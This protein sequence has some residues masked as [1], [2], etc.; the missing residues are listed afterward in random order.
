MSDQLRAGRIFS[1]TDAPTGSSPRLAGLDGARGLACLSIIFAHTSVHFTPRVITDTHLDLVLGHAVTFFF[2]LSAFLLYL[3]YVKRLAAGRSMPPTSTYLRRRVLRIFPA[4]L[5]IFLISNFIFQAVFLVNP[6]TV[7]WSSGNNGTGMMTDPV[8]LL[9]NLTLSQTLF[10]A[11]LQTGINPSWTLTVEWGF[12]LVLPVIGLLLFRRA[13]RSRRPLLAAAVPAAVMFT[14]GMVTQVI[15]QILQERYYPDS[16]LE[17][18]WGANWTAVLSRSSLAFAAVFATGLI[19]AVIYVALSEGK[20]GSVSTIT[21]QC[22]LAAGVVLGGIGAIAMFVINPHYVETLVGFASAAFILLV[23]AP[24]ARREPSRLAR[25]TDWD[26]LRRLGLMAL[27]IYLWHYPVLILVGRLPVAFD[28]NVSGMVTSFLAV[29]VVSVFF[30]WITYRL[31][32]RPAIMLGEG[33][34]P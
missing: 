7:G 12:Y 9:A 15:V 21:L 6:F 31:V 5:V 1:S 13:H 14:V 4:Y 32:E 23:V 33:P 24:L 2:V 20:F 26:P 11:T 16:I 3:P 28:D 25:I 17:G 18:F 27:S 29:A 22:G 34:Q 10:P 19:T 30:G 8:A